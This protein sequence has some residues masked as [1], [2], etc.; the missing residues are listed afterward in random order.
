MNDRKQHVVKMAH[1][2]FIDKGFQSTS[3]QDILEYSG[4]SKGTFYN[5]FSSKSELLTAIFKM[6]DSELE[7]IRNDLLIGQDPAD[8]EIFIK[9]VEMQ[10]KTNRKNKII[11]LFE[12]VMISKDDELKRTIEERK[13]QNIRW[14]YHRLTDIFGI[15]KRQYLLDCAIMFMGM[16]RENIKFYQLAYESDANISQVVRYTVNR[17]VHMVNEI[18]Q[19]EERLIPVQA[20]ERWLP[21]CN[22][23]VRSFRKKLLHQLFIVKNIL[24]QQNN[25]QLNYGDLLD[26]IEEELLDAK[27]PRKFLI[28]SVL[29][30]LQTV[31]DKKVQVELQELSILVQEYFDQI[32]AK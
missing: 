13:I 11:T 4:I 5:Y 27:N 1:Q 32:D 24:H 14:I 18:V 21:D 2:L 3:I 23:H 31:E 9:Q 20:L 8:I 15:D 29:Q 16:L 19:S 12:E 7:K 6:T 22:R 17:L 26:F 10:L 28:D 30:T 25:Q